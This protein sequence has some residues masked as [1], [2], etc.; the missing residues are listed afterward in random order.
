MASPLAIVLEEA[1]LDAVGGE[2]Y[3]PLLARRLERVA[4][5]ILLRQGLGA[6]RVLAESGPQGTRVTVLLPPGPRRVR[7]LVISL[8]SASSA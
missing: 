3:G 8:G 6:A 1:L 7:Q 4:R 2:P 5:A